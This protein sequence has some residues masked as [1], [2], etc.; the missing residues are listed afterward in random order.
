MVGSNTVV[1][2]ALPRLLAVILPLALLAGVLGWL[3]QATTVERPPSAT[4]NVLDAR[5]AGQTGR[6]VVLGNSKV[7][8]DIDRDALSRALGL[9]RGDLVDLSVTGATSPAFYAILKRRVYDA[10]HTPALI[11]VYGSADH[12]LATTLES[13]RDRARVEDQLGAQDD[14]VLGKKVFGRAGG[15]GWLDQARRR[16]TDLH[17]ALMDGLRNGAV[18]WLLGPPGPEPV[19]A[20]GEALAA[21]ALERLFGAD[22]TPTQ[23]E[24]VGVGPIVDT[25]GSVSMGVSGARSIEQTLIPDL[26]ALVHA[27]GARIVFARAPMRTDGADAAERALLSELVA[28]LNEAGAGWV[29]LSGLALGPTDFKDRAHMSSSGRARLTAALA[30]ALTGLDPLG[31]DPLPKAVAPL[32]P[33]G[34]SRT[35][36]GPIFAVT[37][38]RIGRYP[39]AFHAA[40]P[41]LEALSDAALT[42][43]GPGALSP[44]RVL[45]D[46]IP[47][48]PHAARDATFGPCV[49][50]STHAADGLR[51]T[52]TD[53][54]AA[55]HHWSVDAD[56][57]LPLRNGA[58][59]AWW[60]YPGTT[61]RWSFANPWDA[62]RGAFVVASQGRVVVPGTQGG[63][64]RVVDL[65]GAVTESPL[66]GAAFVLGTLQGQG[67]SGPWIV[68]LSSPADGPWLL[69][70][71][72]EIGAGP[73]RTRLLGGPAPGVQ[74]L[75]GRAT[76]AGAP[77]ALV[78]G[79]VETRDRSRFLPLPGLDAVADDALIAAGY[80]DCSPV[81]L[82]ANGKPLSHRPDSG[83]RVDGTW[84]HVAGGLLLAAPG[85]KAP[86]GATLTARLD[87]AGRC[88]RG[89][90]VYPDTSLSWPMDR[91][92]W[93]RL[94]GPPAELRVV[95]AVFGDA[96]TVR[97]DL[98]DGDRVVGGWEIPGAAIA[99]GPVAR[100]YPV[101][102]VPDQPLGVRVTATRGTWVLLHELS[103]RDARPALPGDTEGTP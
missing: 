64:L 53:Q 3:G 76:R 90:W 83:L 72:L 58:T 95:G 57:A 46:G 23:T 99:A 36:V 2:T 80:A 98:L 40:L 32:D 7:H 14:P 28:T 30:A 69:V 86:E 16:R 94:G 87:E 67:P 88:D 20:R 81:E 1:S 11:L 73:A 39:C 77:P 29:D 96:G 43:R 61:L 27:H 62:E 21:P 48:T 74:V 92:G 13:A 19:T 63:V 6:V 56:P 12:F 59:E 17:T 44:I 84:R 50:A 89:T 51:W 78:P 85:R 54:A 25:S 15:A 103:L 100:P 5:L 9:R 71:R 79:P 34:V 31:P 55:E 68:E 41:G 4:A 82:A 65:E 97:V 38:R 22:A 18:G 35:G 33:T 93:R 102:A 24:R 47:L 10:G 66:V 37:P 45:Q 52:A 49:G 70:E 91:Q 8:S 60:V 42:L 75:P 101:G 26:V